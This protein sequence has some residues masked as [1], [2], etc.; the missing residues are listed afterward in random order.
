MTALSYSDCAFARY[1]DR[2]LHHLVHA[3]LID[4]ADANKIPY[5]LAAENRIT[6]TDAANIQVTRSGVS[7]GLVSIPNRYMHTPVEVVDLADVKSVSDLLVCFAK[8]CDA[9]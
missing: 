2:V 6:G 7:T 9:V 1:P 3:A 8:E 5:Q 4:V